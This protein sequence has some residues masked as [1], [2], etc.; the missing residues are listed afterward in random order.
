ME[1][2]QGN[3]ITGMGPSSNDATGSSALGKDEFVKL[4]MTQMQN[5]DPT[6]PQDSEA[7]VAQLAQFAQVELAQAQSARLEAILV[8]QAASNQLAAAQLVGK[9]VTI[10]DDTV[11]VTAD[12]PSTSEIVLGAPAANVT[13]SIT[14]EDGNEVASVK[15]K[16]Q[17][18]GPM[19][20]TWDGMTADGEAPPGEY[21]M[22]VVATDKNSEAVESTI[23]SRRRVEGVTY[24]DGVP[25]LVVGDKSIPLAD[26]LGVHDPDAA[27]G[28]VDLWR[29]PAPALEPSKDDDDSMSAVAPDDGRTSILDDGSATE[30][31]PERPAAETKP[32]PVRAYE[33]ANAKLVKEKEEA[34][35]A[36]RATQ[37][38]LE[39]S[40]H[41]VWME[42]SGTRSKAKKGSF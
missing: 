40:N 23:L 37:A 26:V 17:P 42:L 8:A 18:A 33:D 15:M 13:V 29:P 14:D 21:K 1:I 31:R 35:A 10:A 9:D 19:A 24:E 34:L 41:D 11:A 25:M 5:Q 36:A 28:E 6:S 3:G 2:G 39:A 4:L 12:G 22:T 16:D 20:F 32:D 27:P 38:K 30:A 7:F